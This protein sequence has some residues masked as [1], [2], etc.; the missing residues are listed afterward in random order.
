MGIANNPLEELGIKAQLL[1]RINQA[2]ITYFGHTVRRAGMMERLV[3]EG[4]MNGIEKE[5]GRRHDEWTSWSS[6]P[7]DLERFGQQG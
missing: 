3:V 6:R 2:Y 5:A 1:K 4:K 7:A